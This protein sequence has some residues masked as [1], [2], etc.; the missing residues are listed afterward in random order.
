MN[1]STKAILTIFLVAGAATDISAQRVDSQMAQAVKRNN[2]SI[3]MYT[4]P[5]VLKTNL[6]GIYSLFYERQLQP[7]QS[8]Q[9]GINVANVGFLWNDTKYFSLSAAYKFYLSKKQ[10][11]GHRPYP[12]GFYVSPYVRFLSARETAKGVFSHSRLSEVSYDMFGGGAVAG[13]QMIFG[14][15]LTLDFFVGG[16]YLPVN[17]SHILYTYTSSYKPDVNPGDYKADIRVG[18]CIGYAFK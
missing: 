8:I 5:N 6:L 10:S 2:D 18:I 11:S 12:S 17:S 13:Y 7:K 9:V 16:G 1:I 14:H 4:R 3:R 15:G